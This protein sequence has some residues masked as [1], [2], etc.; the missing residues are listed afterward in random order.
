MVEI[1][2]ICTQTLIDRVYNPPL[3]PWSF[4]PF[5]THNCNASPHTVNTSL[6][7]HTPLLISRKSQQQ[8]KGKKSK[9]QLQP[10][11]PAICVLWHTRQR[12]WTSTKSSCQLRH[13]PPHFAPSQLLID[14]NNEESNDGKEGWLEVARGSRVWFWQ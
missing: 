11:F 6:Q 9:N 3:S 5:V 2:Y 1:K 4:V 8:L 7:L 14:D 12:R 13:R 10:I